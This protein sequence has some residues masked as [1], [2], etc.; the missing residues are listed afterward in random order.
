MRNPFPKCEESSPNQDHQRLK[1]IIKDLLVIHH[2]KQ[3]LAFGSPNTF[4]NF[5]FCCCVSIMSLVNFCG[6]K[7]FIFLCANIHAAECALIDSQTVQENYS[8][9]KVKQNDFTKYL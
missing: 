1:K 6:N 2:E 5:Y 9:W 4:E 7:F 8:R 3:V